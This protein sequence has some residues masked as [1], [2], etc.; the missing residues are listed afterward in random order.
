[1]TPEQDMPSW[2]HDTT[3]TPKQLARK[4]LRYAARQTEDPDL[5]AAAEEH[6]RRKRAGRAM[7]STDP[8][9]EQAIEQYERTGIAKERPSDRLAFPGDSGPF[10]VLD[11]RT[12]DEYAKEHHV[13]ILPAPEQSKEPA[14][15]LVRER[16]Q[17][18]GGTPTY[19][20][21]YPPPPRTTEPIP[22][23]RVSPR[24]GKAP[25]PIQ[26]PAI[27]YPS[28]V[29]RGKTPAAEKARLAIL[30][31]NS[32]KSAERAIPPIVPPPSIVQYP[33]HSRV[34]MPT[35][36]LPTN[37][38]TLPRP[39]ALP[40]L[41]TQR[42][43]QSRNPLPY[44]PLPP[45][46]STQP[47]MAMQRHIPAPPPPPMQPVSGSIITAGRLGALLKRTGHYPI[48]TGKARGLPTVQ[49]PEQNAT[50]T[51]E[52]PVIRQNAPQQVVPQVLQTQ[53]A[54][55]QPSIV[56]GIPSSILLFAGLALVAVNAVN[57]VF[58][59]ASATGVS[60]ASF[61]LG[62]QPIAQSGGILN[63]LPA[64]MFGTILAETALVLFLTLIVAKIS[65]FFNYTVTGIIALFWLAWLVEN[66]AKL[67]SIWKGFVS[68]FQAFGQAKLGT[69]PLEPQNPNHGGSE[70]KGSIP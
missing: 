40:N 17:P 34:G 67:A 31:A 35:V 51:V 58:G 14:E 24:T 47:A 1:M 32:P 4:R 11:P 36:R 15:T 33:G 25:Q 69:S 7:E 59:A 29:M 42:I 52:I 27:P 62:I 18:V 16:R 61:V 66:G 3:L 46:G 53:Q 22:V 55:F 43:P 56:T 5:R 23:V 63:K 8:F 13:P 26:R 50:P 65:S 2:W 6:T 64:N 39:I 44:V 30:A 19:R 9:S 60:V 20:Q 57:Q 45:L 21:D 70:P 68:G 54:R 10:T 49:Q 28:V 37:T 48:V 38:S 12:P 41:R